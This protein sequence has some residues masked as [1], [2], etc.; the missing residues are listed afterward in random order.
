MAQHFFSYHTHSDFCD[1]KASMSDV[2]EQAIDLGMKALAFTS[3]APVPFENTYS[4]RFEALMDYRNAFDALKSRYGNR[5]DLFLGLEADFIPG[6]T[7]SFYEWRKL[8][9]LDFIIGSVHLVK[10]PLSGQKWFIDGAPENYEKG[11]KIVYDGDI[12]RGVRD[13]FQQVRQMIR[14]ERPDIIGHIDK[15]KMNNRDRFF[16]PSEAWFVKDFF[17][18]LDVVKEI[19]GVVEINSRGIYRGKYH[20]CFPHVD[21][22]RRCMELGIP[23][24]LASD[25]HQPIELEH[26]FDLALETAVLAGV[27]NVVMFQP[28]GWQPVPVVQFCSHH[29]TK[30]VR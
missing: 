26:G 9:K 19:G 2:C 14:S 17:Q 27:K 8:L 13:Y 4:L 25:T 3:H 10:D 23:L 16:H 29:S 5:L 28:N 15:V 6:E 12:Q 1:G 7:V 20:E 18:T 22:I 24:T 11:L 30:E 21:G